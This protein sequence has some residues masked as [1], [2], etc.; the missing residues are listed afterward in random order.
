MIT[1]QS[2]HI[3]I[4]HPYQGF[5]MVE[6][7][8]VM[9]I[10]AIIFSFIMVNL[11]NVIPKANVKG[12]AEVVVA[13]LREQQMK[14]L[15]GYESVTGGSSNYGVF[16][17]NDRYILFTGDVYVVGLDDSYTVML[18]PGLAFDTSNLPLSTLVFLKGSG[19]VRNY[20]EILNSIAI[21]N[22]ST[23]ETI[24][25]EFNQLGVLTIL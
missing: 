5:T 20:N 25:I 12:A 16:F 21:R 13:D 9:S 11:S 1:I 4:N 23:L 7:L 3:V 18:E 10:L 24:T 2:K 6:L 8:L 17:E 15:S 19:E 14:A 22:T